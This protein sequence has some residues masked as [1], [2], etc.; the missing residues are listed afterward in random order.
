MVDI[1]LQKSLA[2]AGV[3]SRRE[4]ERHILAGRVRVNGARITVLGSKVDPKRDRVEFR[5][6]LVKAGSPSIYIALNKPRG[7]VTSCK[8]PQEKIITDLIDINERIFPIGRL[9]KDSEGLLL[10]TNDGRLHHQLSHPS[11]E[12]QKVYH[13]TVSKP[14]H[15]VDLKKL[16]EGIVLNGVRTRPAKVRRLSS[17]RFGITLKEGRNRQIRRMVG[18]L[19][20]QVV[21]LKRVQMAN[22]RLGDLAVGAWRFLKNDE[23]EKLSINVFK[24]KTA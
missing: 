12:H 8:Q 21:Q 20:Y 22:I 9:D 7:Y 1:R 3:C 23:K 2:D 14:I 17:K 11:H 10:L 16:S 15:H 4:G 5:G 19:G 6:R 13:V 18:K 24:G